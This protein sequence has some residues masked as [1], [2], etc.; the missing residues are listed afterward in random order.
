MIPTI[1]L[2]SE[3]S[4][5]QADATPIDWFPNRP[6]FVP[7]S[8]AE[9]KGTTNWTL[10]S[11][12]GPST[13]DGK[14]GPNIQFFIG[15][16]GINIWLVALASFML[17]PAILVSWES[18]KERPGTFYGWMFLLQGGAIGAFLSFDVILF[19]VF[20]ELTLI[21]AFFLIGRWGIGSGRRDAARKFFLYTLAGSLLT[22][23]GM[24]GVVMTNPHPD[25]GQITF[26]LP[27]LTKNVQ[28]GM[29]TRI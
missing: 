7:G 15:V 6:E 24:I 12:S 27:D 3:R 26:S 28:D 4:S 13:S 17:I 1:S 16:D 2:L 20:F 23:L 5:T 9:I 11:L 18:I 22:L 25:S 29:H 21:P 10:L 14:T 19:Y 8:H